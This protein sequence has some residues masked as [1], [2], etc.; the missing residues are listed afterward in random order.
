MYSWYVYKPPNLGPDITARLT[1][2]TR[3]F[4]KD[5]PS[6]G[7][8]H[9][10]DWEGAIV[11]LKSATSTAADNIAAV[12]PSAHGGWTCSTTG[13]TLEGTRPLLKYEST[14]PVNHAT[15]LTKTKG[16]EQP[17]VAWEVLPVASRDAL[18]TADFGS[19]IVPFKDSTF[20]NNL[21]AATF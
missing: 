18:Q 4:P 15:D 6:T 14:W 5:S 20:T 3:Y 12:C 11:Y 19:A 13:F 17:L 10:H 9:R 21:N 16:G 1:C 2:D 8:G 7:L